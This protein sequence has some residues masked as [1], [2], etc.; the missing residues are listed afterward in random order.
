MYQKSKKS[1]KGRFFVEIAAESIFKPTCFEYVIIAIDAWHCTR[2]EKMAKN[3][4]LNV[5]AQ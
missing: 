2:L 3:A 1:K 4:S 5:T